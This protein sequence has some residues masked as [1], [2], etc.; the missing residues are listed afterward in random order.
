[1][2][3][4]VEKIL[5]DATMHSAVH[6]YTTIELH[7]PLDRRLAHAV[8]GVHG[9]AS[10]SVDIS[11]SAVVVGGGGGSGSGS[12][13]GSSRGDR[14]KRRRGVRIYGICS[15]ESFENCTAMAAL[16]ARK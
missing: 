2:V 1:M 11:S 5:H 16:R 3:A 7:K 10:T 4:H 13:S 6:G 8:A 12:G 9:I 14:T 15:L